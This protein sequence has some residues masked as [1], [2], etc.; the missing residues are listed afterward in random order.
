[1]RIALLG[2]A[3]ETN[4]FSLVPATYREFKGTGFDRGQELVDD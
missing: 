4:T 1:M 3:H 2:M